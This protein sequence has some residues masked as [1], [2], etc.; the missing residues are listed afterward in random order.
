M[1]YINKTEAIS[2][3]QLI[4]SGEIGD[5]NV[6]QVFDVNGNF[7][8]QGHW[9]NDCILERKGILGQARKAGTGHTIQFRQVK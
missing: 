3:S 2:L 6:I 7:V 5:G 8:C 1:R 9:Y 4:L